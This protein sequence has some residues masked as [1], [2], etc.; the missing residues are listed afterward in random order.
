MKNDLERV[1]VAKYPE[2]GLA[3]K[4]LL[5]LGAMGALMS[6]SGPT[7]FGLFD[8]AETAKSA[9]KTLAADKGLKLF[10]VGPILEADPI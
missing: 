6:G 4:K 9:K 8:N 3:K 1:T 7:V 10:L 2:I 5:N